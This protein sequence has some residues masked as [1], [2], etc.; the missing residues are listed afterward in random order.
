MAHPR[1]QSGS[2]KEANMRNPKKGGQMDKEE[3][4][5]HKEQQRLGSRRSKRT[6]KPKGKG[7]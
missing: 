5:N 4:D 7:R 2:G 1:I 3:A 6:T